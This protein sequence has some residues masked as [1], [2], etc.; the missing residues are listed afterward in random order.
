MERA[1][2]PPTATGRGASSPRRVPVLLLAV[3]CGMTVG[4]LYLALPLLDVLADHFDASQPSTSLVVVLSQAA[5][6]LGL[7]LVVPLG[8][9]LDQRRLILVLMAVEAAALLAAALAPSLALL[10]LVAFG[11]G[12]G[13]VVV[14]VMVP[15]AA[16]RAPEHARG[17]VLASVM[18][19]LLIG[20]L[21]VRFLSGVL[22]ELVGWRPVYLGAAAASLILTLLL[23]LR[24]RPEAKRPEPATHGYGALIASL[25]GLLREHAVLRERAL[26]GALCFAAFAAFWTP[27]PF[28]LAGDPYHYGSGAV[29]LV[30]LLG[31]GGVVAA[32]IAGRQADRA[33]GGRLTFLMLTGVTL[34]FL[35]ALGGGSQLW[36]LLLAAILVDFTA[37]G[38]HLSN[39]GE[40][41]RLPVQI[42]GRVTSVY[43]TAYFMGGA[44]GGMASA[45]AYAAWGWS[46]VCLLGGGL[47]GVAALVCGIRWWR[48][49]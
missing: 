35:P 6:A 13:A 32:G 22:G 43:M 1:V 39:Q 31:V 40:I 48:D 33:P 49:R 15:Y 18:S 36:L 2:T 47:S 21:L 20:S 34:S 9:M 26:Y 25:P 14:M 8:D 42:R 46:A 7:V 16:S 29:G 38:A 28:L 4:N 27:L 3:A 23:A 10:Y 12:A 37:Q 5:Y 41:Y 45:G 19:G 11:V 17:R 24:L 30:S 44:V